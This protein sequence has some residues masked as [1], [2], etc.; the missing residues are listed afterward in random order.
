MTYEPVSGRLLTQTSYPDGEDHAGHRAHDDAD[1]HDQL[2]AADAA[3]VERS[4][5]TTSSPTSPRSTGRASLQGGAHVGTKYT[6]DTA[7]GNVTA[8]TRTPTAAGTPTSATYCNG[9]DCPKGLVKS[10]TDE[11]GDVTTYGDFD[12]NGLPQTM[13][14]PKGNDIASGFPVP[15]GHPGS[16]HA[17]EHRW[18]YRYDAVGNLL[19]SSDPRN[20]DAQSN[21]TV[22]D[23]EREVHDRVHLRRVRPRHQAGDAEGLG[24]R[25]RTSPRAGPTTATAT[26]SRDANAGTGRSTTAT[27]SKTDQ[28]LTVTQDGLVARQQRPAGNAYTARR[29]RRRSPTTPT[30]CSSARTDPRGARRPA[31]DGPDCRTPRSGRA[32]TPGRVVAEI[33]THATETPAQS[34]RWR[35]TRAA[36]SSARSTR[37]A[38]PTPTATAATPT[39][40]PPR[41]RSPTATATSTTTSRGCATVLRLQQGRRDHVADRAPGA[42]RR[43]R[44]D[45]KIDEYDYDADG[46]VVKHVLPR[47]YHD[48]P[49]GFT[50]ARATSPTPTSTTTATSCD[51]RSTRYGRGHRV[52]APRR[53]RGRLDDDAARR[54]RR[55]A[56]PRTTAPTRTSPRTTPTTPTAT[57]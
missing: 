54:D 25:Q 49:T 40:A 20:P 43:H 7:T 31:S 47:N 23:A 14:D 10:E 17:A 5:P 42:R 27:F 1:V 52:N 12:A 35:W 19:S 24:Q 8:V 29:G 44:L 48:R 3:A 34:A 32:T 37:S 45:R 28:P 9:T 22:A 46:N 21:P 33:R 11:V 56:A 38:T 41:R 15:A 30:T 2:R 18:L 53:R 39:P 26:S 6:V 50:S 16:A 55:D 36:T 4:R 13:V 57:C 51:S